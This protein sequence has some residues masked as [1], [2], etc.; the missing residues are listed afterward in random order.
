MH[1]PMFQV[2]FTLPMFCYFCGSLIQCLKRWIDAPELAVGDESY[3][4]PPQKVDP[5]KAERPSQTKP[6]EKKKKRAPKIPATNDGHCVDDDF[7]IYLEETLK[8]HRFGPCWMPSW[9]FGDPRFVDEENPLYDLSAKPNSDWRENLTFAKFRQFYDY[10][11]TSNRCDRYCSEFIQYHPDI[12]LYPPPPNRRIYDEI[13]RDFIRRCENY[14]NLG[15][16]IPAE[17]LP[18]DD[19]NTKDR[20]FVGKRE[21]STRLTPIREEPQPYPHPDIFPQLEPGARLFIIRKHID[22]QGLY[23]RLVPDRIMNAHEL[24]VLADTLFGYRIFLICHFYLM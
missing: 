19:Y 3:W 13:E 20:F 5:P 10:L 8:G 7:K 1:V 9:E 11:K 18:V 12:L 4:E 22:A 2:Y 6:V 23:E 14:Y 17:K 16:K 21:S 24:E 15:V